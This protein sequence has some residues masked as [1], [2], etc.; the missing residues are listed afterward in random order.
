MKVILLED[1][2]KLGAP[3][4]IVEVAEGYARN[5]LV[6]RGLAT[7]ATKSAISQLDNM[8]RVDERR[9]T[10]LRGSAQE[11]AGQLE[12]KTLVMPAKIGKGGRLYGSISAA[13]IA[14]EIQTQLGQTV[15][16]KK[17]QLPEII[18]EVGVYTVPV[19]LHRDVK[20]DLKIQVG[21]A[22]EEVAPVEAEAVPA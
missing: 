2:E 21:D 14:E 13:D 10:R 8:K 6:P 1:V 17:V 4:E 11:Q 16:R 15:D 22:V 7:P 20:V 5:F 9:Q 18:R 3:L 12:G 19:A